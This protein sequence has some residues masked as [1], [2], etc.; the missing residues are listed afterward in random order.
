MQ[1]NMLFRVSE[2]RMLREKIKQA[3]M[4]KIEVMEC[5]KSALSCTNICADTITNTHILITFF[6]LIKIFCVGQKHSWFMSFNAIY[7]RRA[8]IQREKVGAFLSRT[9]VWYGAGMYLVKR[10]VY[11]FFSFAINHE[12]NKQNGYALVWF[13]MHFFSEFFFFNSL[14]ILHNTGSDSE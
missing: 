6:H 1:G 12:F 5:D 10:C 9:C 8:E 2:R 11:F 3:N 4:V 13:H 7:N 14:L